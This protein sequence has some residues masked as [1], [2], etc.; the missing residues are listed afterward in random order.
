[1]LHG[2]SR[3][4]SVVSF[5]LLVACKPCSGCCGEEKVYRE[6]F[7]RV[8]ETLVWRDASGTRTTRLEV[9]P[10]VD[11]RVRLVFEGPPMPGDERTAVVQFWTRPPEAGGHLRPSRPPAELEWTLEDGR[12]IRFD[13]A[14]AVSVPLACTLTSRITGR[15][16]DADDCDVVERYEDLSECTA[17]FLVRRE[18][19]VALANAQISASVGDEIAVLELR[20]V[21]AVDPEPDDAGVR[22]DGG[23]C[24]STSCVNGTL[25]SEDGCFCVCSSGWFGE[26]CDRG[27][28]EVSTIAG[29]AGAPGFVDGA[30]GAEGR[31]F[32]P[33]AL[34]VWNERIV[35]ADRGNEVLRTYDPREGS[36]ATLAG[37]PGRGSVDGSLATA[38]F[39]RVV[40]LASEPDG[41][42][43]VLEADPV[44]IRRV[45]D[46][47]V[48]TLAH[49]A[50]PI[51][52]AIA[53][54]DDRIYVSTFDAVLSLSLSGGDATELVPAGGLDWA[55]GR[56]PEVSVV[57]AV[58]L[59][60]APDGERLWIVEAGADAA[61]GRVL[62]GAVRELRL[63]T[64][65]LTTLAGRVGFRRSGSLLVGPS[66]VAGVDARTLVV[67]E[68]PVHRL[69]WVLS[70]SGAGWIPWDLAGDPSTGSTDVDGEAGDSDGRG[71]AARF[72]TPS[73]VVVWNGEL[74]VS[75]AGN[76]TLRRVI[77][78]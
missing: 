4:G 50:L 17:T 6:S 57:S 8:F 30:A 67:V 64:L 55:D 19:N 63:D 46:G 66:A 52:T 1:V 21:A 23:P 5:A 12:P 31:L 60:L 10:E 74:F 26:A 42:L 48:S 24:G 41:G 59:V 39:G 77:T 45:V 3:W 61:S 9:P 43:L 71:S 69:R 37:A 15:S 62:G 16:V 44:R 25:R 75:D 22:T 29:V 49:A 68:R 54:G 53:R 40:D 20:A 76:H 65:E 38:G 51:A 18:P 36:L 14:G 11:T 7:D 27:E 2:P 32:Y 56:V 33:G 58:D 47:A 78:D 35:I 72:D 28:A 13:A 34:A 70:P 73:A